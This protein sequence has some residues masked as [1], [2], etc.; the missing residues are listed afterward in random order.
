MVVI[1][2]EAKARASPVILLRTGL[3]C[4]PIGRLGYA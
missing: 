4:S 1:D 2:A 3:R